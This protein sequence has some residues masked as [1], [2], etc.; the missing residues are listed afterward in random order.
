[1]LHCKLRSIVTRFT[2]RV[3]SCDNALQEVDLISYGTSFLLSMQA[4]RKML[5]MFLSTY[6]LPE[7]PEIV[8]LLESTLSLKNLTS[9]C[10]LLV[11][12]K[13]NNRVK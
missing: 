6:F 2:I 12:T 4:A 5:P 1:M 10:F 7:T 8:G 9:L 3:V 13:F 11:A